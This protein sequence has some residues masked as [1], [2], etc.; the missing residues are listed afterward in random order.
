MVL[1]LCSHKNIFLLLSPLL[2][3]HPRYRII[4]V[5]IYIAVTFCT[6]RLEQVWLQETAVLTVHLVSAFV[7]FGSGC[8]Y[9]II[10]AY[11]SVHMHPL[12]ANR[13]IGLIRSFFAFVAITS[14]FIGILWKYLSSYEVRWNL[15]CFVGSDIKRQDSENMKELKMGPKVLQQTATDGFRYAFFDT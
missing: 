11:I 6:I 3:K 15:T 5:G 2:V 9:M 7:C 13:H 8:V 12:Y 14:F 4:P 1:P 10:Q